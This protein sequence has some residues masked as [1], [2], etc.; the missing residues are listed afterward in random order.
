M[1]E[2]VVV[3]VAGPDR[4]VR[5][6]LGAEL[7]VGS[8]PAAGMRL[9]DPSV[10]SRHARIFA[11]GKKLRVEALDPGSGVQL[12]GVELDR[13]RR[14]R[15]GDQLLL[16]ATVVEVVTADAAAML[17]PAG[18]PLRVVETSADFVPHQFL[19]E[20]MHS[21]NRYGALASWT[22]SHVKLQTR[23]ATFGLLALSALAVY[24]FVL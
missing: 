4:G 10:A 16:G 14:L 13:V 20:P 11:D 1:E 9:T 2:L 18:R 21:H 15:P 19:E 3:V 22:D 24:I 17:A 7:V 12:N 6:T 8:A 5:A 23:I